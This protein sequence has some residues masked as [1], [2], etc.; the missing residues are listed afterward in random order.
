MVGGVPPWLLANRRRALRLLALI[1]IYLVVA[2]VL[3][4]PAS[5]EPAGWRI[6]AIFFATIAGLMLRPLPGAPLVLIGL[7]AFVLVG[8]LPMAEALSGFASPS[9]WLVLTA[10]ITRTSSRRPDWRAASLSSSSASL[11]AALW[12]CRP[13]WS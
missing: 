13:R 1:A 10:M 11:A 12:G 6:T 2:H 3:P 5:V 8:G 7:M 4:R 9:V